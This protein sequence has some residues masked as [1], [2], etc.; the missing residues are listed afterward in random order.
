MTLYV[1]LFIIALC[2][3]MAISVSVFGTGSKR[4]KLF[5]E[6]YF[7]IEETEDKIG[8]FYTKGGDYSAT[9]KIEN[10]VVQ[11][12]AN[13]DSYYSYA[14]LFNALVQTLGEGYALHKQDVFCMQKFTPERGEKRE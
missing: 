12:C 5:K 10:P 14:N 1:I 13:V 3:G 11:Y 8:V 4:K 6:I 9:L 7:S 2:G